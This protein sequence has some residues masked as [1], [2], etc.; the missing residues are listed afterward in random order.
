MSKQVSN[1]NEHINL[2]YRYLREANVLDLVSDPRELSDEQIYRFYAMLIGISLNRD[3]LFE[4]CRK[5]A[6]DHWPELVQEDIQDA[7]RFQVVANN[8]ELLNHL[9]TLLLRQGSVS[10]RDD[11]GILNCIVDGRRG[12][13]YALRRIEERALRLR[14][15]EL[16]K[17]EPAF[18][19]YVDRVLKR[20]YFKRSL[21]GYTILRQ[22]LLLLLNDCSLLQ[23]LSKRLYPELAKIFK[24]SKEAVERNLRYLFKTLRQ[25]EEERLEQIARQISFFDHRVILHKFD[26]ETSKL[27]R[28]DPKNQSSIQLHRSF[29]RKILLG[30]IEK[31]DLNKGKYSKEYLAEKY[32]HNYL[33][34]PGNGK[35]VLKLVQILYELVLHAAQLKDEHDHDAELN[36]LDRT[37]KEEV[38]RRISAAYAGSKKDKK[39]DDGDDGDDGE[40]G[41]SGGAMPDRRLPSLQP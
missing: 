32:Q 12:P 22:A 30:T 3:P 21:R 39:K 11:R 18:L 10:Y 38:E 4:E 19:A 25:D 28:Q 34:Y 24:I 27:M 40:G 37:I 2:L 29:A 35:S 15:K 6:Q 26:E 8:S 14:D 7:T 17:A 13:Q 41:T 20:F 9:N 36:W 1:E 33:V 16:V 5:A 23:P 31:E